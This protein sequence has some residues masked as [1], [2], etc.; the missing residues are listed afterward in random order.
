[1]RRLN[2]PAKQTFHSP[3]LVALILGVTTAIGA[4]LRLHQLSAKSLWIDEAASVSFASMPWRAF[5]RAILTYEGNMSLY[6]FLLR[7]WM[8]LGDSEFAVRSLSVLFAVLTIPAIYLLGERL[9][10]RA[11][12]LTAAALLSVHGF[13]IQWS[14]EARGYTLL[15]LLLVLAAYFF[16]RAMESEKGYSYWIAFA[17]TAALSFY[18]HIFAVFFLAACALSIAFPKPYR[19]RTQNIILVAVLIEHLIAPMVLF[20]L[21]HREATQISW[22]QRPSLGDIFQFLLLLTG[23][24]GILLLFI[25]F[26]LGALAFVGSAGVDRSDRASERR[27]EKDRWARRLLLLW[28]LLPPLV[29]LAASPIKPLFF[30]T[31]MLMCVPALLLLAARGLVHL[32]N[33]PARRWAGAAAFA[34]VITLSGWGTH[35]YFINFA[36]ESTDWRSAVNYILENQRLGD[37]VVIFSS[38]ARCYRYYADRG[39]SQHRV[40][41]AP[42]VL[43]PPDPRRPVSHDEVTSDTAGHERVWLLLNDEQ[44]K[45]TELA[46]VHSTLAERLRPQEERVFPGKIPITVVLYGRPQ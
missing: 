32:Y 42:D 28:L 25:Y 31:Y 2:Q 5:V 4:A 29:T 16:I 3:F 44:E 18:V 12:G 40:A 46:I 26:A 30:A 39:E 8:H 22:L 45:P 23:Q 10:D 20:V 6:Y 24:G 17:V 33:L 9:F 43:Y 15:T 1:M 21:M 13:H 27:P 11:T 14:Q 34:L 7:G 41:T 38:H 37:G 35:Q 19:A 36:A